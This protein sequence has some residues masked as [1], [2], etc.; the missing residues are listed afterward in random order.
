MLYV[1]WWLG[2]KALIWSS[3]LY[4]SILVRPQRM[5]IVIDDSG[6]LSVCHVASLCKHC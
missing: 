3:L 2:S 5:T 4:T 6:R 1:A